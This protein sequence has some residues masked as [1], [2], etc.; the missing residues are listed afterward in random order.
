MQEAQWSILR[1]E[2]S[3]TSTVLLFHLTNHYALLYALR[4]WVDEDGNPVRQMLTA[5][6]GQRPTVWLDWAEARKIILG[7]SGYNLMRIKGKRGTAV[8]MTEVAGLE[9]APCPDVD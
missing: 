5:R 4:E 2:F 1:S 9:Q 3:D 7:W 8:P 6:R